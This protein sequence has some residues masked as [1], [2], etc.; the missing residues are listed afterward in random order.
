MPQKNICP[1]KT[2]VVEPAGVTWMLLNKVRWA[3]FELETW[4]VWVGSE[5]G[6]DLITGWD[7][8]AIFVTEG[9]MNDSV[10]H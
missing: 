6:L 7:W 3:E 4:L 5:L 8:P 2:P 9:M 10:L 1:W